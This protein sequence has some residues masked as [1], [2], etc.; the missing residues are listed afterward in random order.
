MGSSSIEARDAMVEFSKA[1]LLGLTGLFVLRNFMPEG[2]APRATKEVLD[3]TPG[4]RA[5]KMSF[6]LS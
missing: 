5:V 4:P 6:C 1:L 2:D 3:E